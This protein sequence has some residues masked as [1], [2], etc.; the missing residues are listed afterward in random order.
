MKENKKLSVELEKIYKHCNYI[1]EMCKYDCMK[2]PLCFLDSA[3][4]RYYLCDI[5][6]E[7]LLRLNEYERENENYEK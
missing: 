5:V 7:L 2:C 4:F 1:C 3:N 6:S